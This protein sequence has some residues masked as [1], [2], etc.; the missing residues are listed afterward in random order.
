VADHKPPHPRAN[1]RAVWQHGQLR[2]SSRPMSWA[3]LVV[4]ALLIWS[5]LYGS[6]FLLFA[7]LTA[8]LSRY[9]PTL[10]LWKQKGSTGDAL[11]VRV[12]ALLLIATVVEFAPRGSVAWIRPR[13]HARAARAARSP[14]QQPFS[15]LQS[16]SLGRE[17]PFDPRGQRTTLRG[18]SRPTELD[19]RLHWGPHQRSR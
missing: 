11:A 14:S 19:S 13:R 15:A 7:V 18:A 3:R 2:A 5:P 12:D 1:P 10:E 16:R 6:I 9:G 4:I 8:L 17:R